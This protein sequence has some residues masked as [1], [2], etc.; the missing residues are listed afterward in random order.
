MKGDP[1]PKLSVSILLV[2]VLDT[3]LLSRIDYEDEE[4]A[5]GEAVRS[6]G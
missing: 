2:L 4:G 1:E 3:V 5:L 6:R